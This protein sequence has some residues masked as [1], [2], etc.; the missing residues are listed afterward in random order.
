MIPATA[1]KHAGGAKM[2]PIK[3][4]TTRQYHGT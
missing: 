3:L 2:V 4:Q 1:K